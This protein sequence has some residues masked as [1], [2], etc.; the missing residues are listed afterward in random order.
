MNTSLYVI[1]YRGKLIDAELRKWMLV[2]VR[3]SFLRQRSRCKVRYSSVLDDE[4]VLLRCMVAGVDVEDL[5]VVRRLYPVRRHAFLY[6]AE[7]QAKSLVG[8]GRRS[9]SC[10]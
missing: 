7:D 5:G 8:I 4:R 2:V 10:G 3:D 6:V 9:R 1:E